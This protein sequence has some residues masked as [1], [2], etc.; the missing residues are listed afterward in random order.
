MD[1]WSF[2]PKCG[3][4]FDPEA[5]E[6][7]SCGAATPN[8]ATVASGEVTSATD[9]DLEALESELREALAP[10]LQLINRMGQGGMGTVFLARDP[11]LKRNVVVK[12]LSPELA[13]DPT[14][15]ARFAREAESAA[16]VSHPNVINVYSVG[17]LP[18][19]GTSYFVMQHVDGPTLGEKFP[20]GTAVPEALVKQIIGEVASALAAAHERGLVHRD[21][22]PNN[23]MIERDSGR[24][25]VLDFGISA[26][27]T[28]EVAG[29]STKL[30]VQGTSIGTPQY[31]SPE[32]AAGEEVTGASDVYSLG[33]VAFELL[34]GRPPFDETNAM[35]L[36]AAHIH[37]EPPKSALLRPDVDPQLAGLVDR[38]LAKDPGRRVP[39][40]DLSRYLV[41]PSQPVIEWPPPGLQPLWS[42]GAT[43]SRL[44]GKVVATGIAFFALLYLQPRIATGS[45][46]EA[47][48]SWIWNVLGTGS[49]IDRLFL[50]Q[51]DCAIRRGVGL[52]CPPVQVEATA[53]WLTGLLALAGVVML[54]CVVIGSRTVS[55]GWM[56]RQARQCGYPDRVLAS[57]AWD[58]YGDT[59]DL[60]NGT[61]PHALES[62]EDRLATWRRRWHV[63]QWYWLGVATSAVLPVLW[64]LGLFRVGGTH[65]HWLNGPEFL[66]FMLPMAVAVAIRGRIVGRRV[67]MSARQMER[68]KRGRLATTT[69]HQDLVGVW[70]RSIGRDWQTASPPRPRVLVPALATVAAFVLFSTSLVAAG[71]LLFSLWTTP[72]L[73]SWAWIWLDHVDRNK[74]SER[75]STVDST[76]VALFQEQLRPNGNRRESDATF[77]EAAAA[78]RALRPSNRGWSRIDWETVWPQLDTGRPLL[79]GSALQL[80]AASRTS[81]SWEAGWRRLAVAIAETPYE[82]VDTVSIALTSA[83]FRARL[84]GAVLAF[85]RGEQSAARRMVAENLALGHYLWSQPRSYFAGVREILRTLNA[86]EHMMRAIPDSL[87]T[88]THGRLRERVGAGLEASTR[89]FDFLDMSA[90]LMADPD[91]PRGEKYVGR[92]H[93]APEL[94]ARLARFALLGFCAN[95]REVMFGMARSRRALVARVDSALVETPAVREVLRSAQSKLDSAITMTPGLLGAIGRIR[96]CLTIEAW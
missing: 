17:E 77:L 8:A 32:Q 57:V 5:K 71:S 29:K 81:A 88:V 76:I 2:C 62:L 53:L 56:L 37:K 41:P 63:T 60:L 28:S 85:D 54:S 11:A 94:R 59:A 6:C 49:V 42:F 90:I 73:R 1:D 84:A 72:T 82:Y 26:A 68:V 21:I 25:I 15:R 14:A 55:L 86:S 92:K 80:E 93:L 65:D 64:V 38:C 20:E 52:D 36:L 46:T 23:I 79:R 39:A 51:T 44:G 58:E 95:G 89:L 87:S 91:A 12:V 10:G 67:L 9:S 75:W 22:K 96:W 13:H 50:W 24:A 70:L 43:L 69:A 3:T 35:A 83:M 61:G 74:T 47:E 45:W 18:R 40:A 16:A 4:K 27:I 48:S 7:S 78:W 31:M 33:L 34:T 66:V 30:T 19:S